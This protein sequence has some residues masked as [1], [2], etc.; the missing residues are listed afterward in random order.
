VLRSARGRAVR[1]LAE[2]AARFP[3]LL[4]TH[5]DTSGLDD[6]DAA[7]AHAIV[8][9]VVRRWM[10]LVYLLDQVLRQPF[11]TLQAPLQG[12]LLA[13]A[14]QLMLL[15][16]IPAHAAL[17]ESVEIAKGVSGR[18]G[19]GLVNAILRRV[20]AMRSEHARTT[21]PWAGRRD[22]LPMPDGG[23]LGL[24]DVLLP[25]N[26][27][28][29]LAIATSH[30][31]WLL[32]RWKQEHGDPASS[33]ALHSLIAPPTVLNTAHATGPLPALLK[34]HTAPGHHTFAGSRD[35]LT[36]L[37]ASRD[38]LWVQD[39]ASA[40]AVASLAAERPS[41]VLDLCAG[42]GTKTRQLAA[43]FP[44][45]QIIATDIE[46]TRLNVLARVY[47]HQERVQVL[48][49]ERVREICTGRA[50][51]ILLD[52]P[53]SNTGVLA[54]RPEARYRAGPAQ[55]DRLNAIQRQV[56]VDAIPLLNES[57]RGRILYST[58]SID[59]QENDAII[60]WSAKWHRFRSTHRRQ[61]LPAGLPGQAPDAY[62]DGA[63]STL[64]S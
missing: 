36:H 11:A 31:R 56:I 45:A 48:P 9:S 44:E 40:L 64:L 34:P 14:G 35:D 20:A 4:P 10:T 46:P 50:D 53:C 59:S 42:Q 21:E 58:C 26:P 12:I 55:L 32:D 29:R 7:L 41:L 3:D 62:H 23:S 61:T 2:H 49:F 13:G 47:A 15:D 52:V 33:L 8:D 17:N 63:F 16:R 22:R 38:D 6:R 43:V 27:P 18:G 19:V 5:L 28:D 60:A 1:A 24:V 37:L 25:E 39:P 30:P 57:P 51:L 54:R